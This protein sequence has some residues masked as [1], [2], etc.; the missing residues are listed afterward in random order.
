MRLYRLSSMPA[1][2]FGD[3]A[4]EGRDA[5]RILA[6]ER[7]VYLESNFGREPLHAYLVA[8]SIAMFGRTPAAVRLPSALAGCLTI[9]GL[10]G[11]TRK[12]FGT[13]AGLIAAFLFAFSVWAVMLGRLATR[14]AL[15]PCVLSFAFWAGISAWQRRDAR[16]WFVAGLLFGISLYTYTPIRVIIFILPL[17]M[18]VVLMQGS[19]QIGR[20]H[21]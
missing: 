1:G 17:W 19:A 15:L 4:A 2:L 9:I 5:L 14:P 12:L 20:A 21:V 11:L 3:E 8:G 7:P 16:R 10:F 13:R 6:G 18:L